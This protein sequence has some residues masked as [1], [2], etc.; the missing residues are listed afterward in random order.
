[1]MVK[2]LQL[3]ATSLQLLLRPQSRLRKE[4][5]QEAVFRLATK[6]IGSAPNLRVLKQDVAF[7]GVWLGHPDVRVPA[8]RSASPCLLKEGRAQ[9]S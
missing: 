7:A 3:W 2:L 6:T 8:G 1:M 9:V 4:R 5:G